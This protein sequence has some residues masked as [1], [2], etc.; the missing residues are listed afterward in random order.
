MNFLRKENASKLER[1]QNYVIGGDP[2]DLKVHFLIVINS[3]QTYFKRLNDTKWTTKV[4][5]ATSTGKKRKK[6]EIK[7]MGES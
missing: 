2:D 5:R 1:I 6:A 3:S 4:R 7:E